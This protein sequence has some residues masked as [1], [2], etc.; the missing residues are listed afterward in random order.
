MMLS[1]ADFEEFFPHLF[2]SN[3]DLPVGHPIVTSHLTCIGRWE[4]DGG[5]VRPRLSR[6]M[7]SA[8]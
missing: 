8:P 1:K 4:D 6:P 3:D 5:A 7:A 2:Q